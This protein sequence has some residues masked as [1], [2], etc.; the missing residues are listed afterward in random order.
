MKF[1]LLI[2]VILPFMPANAQQKNNQFILNGE[3]S[4]Q[5]E[6]WIILSYTNSEGKRVKDSSTLENGKFIISGNINYPTKGLLSGNFASTTSE[7]LHSTDLYLEPTS[8]T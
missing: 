1:L 8:L 7:S 4:S 3:V 6:G 5:K 2:L